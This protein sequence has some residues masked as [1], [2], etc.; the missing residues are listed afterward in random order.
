MGMMIYSC[1]LAVALIASSPWWLW[2][3]ATSGRYRAG[4]WGRL[5]FVPAE[6]I[7]AVDGRD[8]IWLHAVS[9]GEVLAAEQLI[10]ELKTVLP[11]WVVAVSTTTASGQAPARSSPATGSGCSA[12]G[13]G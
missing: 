1:L 4:L 8:V 10:A 2:R 6:L 9:V 12:C 13:N 3:M 5:G 11:A 7:G